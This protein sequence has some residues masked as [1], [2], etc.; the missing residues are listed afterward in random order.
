M[1]TENVEGPEFKTG[2]FVKVERDGDMVT[3]TG[4]TSDGFV[5]LSVETVKKL[6]TVLQKIVE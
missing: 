5:E 1:H 3:L 2:N 4:D 6:I